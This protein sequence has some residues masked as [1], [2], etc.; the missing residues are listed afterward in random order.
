[1]T[2][3]VSVIVP[4]YNAELHIERCITSLLSQTLKECEFIFVN[5]GSQDSSRQ[6]IE[7]YQRVNKRIRL[8]NQN[9]QGVSAARNAGL[10]IAKG[11]YIGFVD[12][13][14]VVSP[15][16]YEYLCLEAAS[17]RCD[18]VISNLTSEMDGVERIH[19]FPF[20]KDRVLD[21]HYIKKE[22]IPFL[23]SHD[24]FNSVCNKLFNLKVV[25]ENHVKFPN[26]ITLGEDGLFNLQFFCASSRVKYINESFYFYKETAGSAT[27]NLKTKDYFHHALETYNRELNGV[28]K[29]LGKDE[30]YRLKALKLIK[31]VRSFIHLYLDPEN[32]LERTKRFQYVKRMIKDPTV[33]EAMTLSAD[34]LKV[35]E[36][37][38]ERWMLYLINRE[39]LLGLYFLTAY[40]RYRNRKSSERGELK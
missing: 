31:S 13:D 28:Q 8:I 35:Y 27:R 30:L 33:K 5:D 24:T 34:Q 22:I 9:N 3:K 39:Q 40:S 2:I 7:Q 25:K 16:M 10:E 23:I 12:A 17:D 37:R 18:V 38:Y 11:A 6:I 26:Q 19:G 20:L 1:M 21:Y 15:T 4:V 14:D 36:G 32:E 29:L